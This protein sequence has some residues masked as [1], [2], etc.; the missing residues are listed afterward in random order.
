M[1]APIYDYRGIIIAAVSVSGDKA[2]ISKERDG[3]TAALV[4]KAAQGISSRI[5]YKKP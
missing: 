3:E 5:G 2:V 1:A 4:M